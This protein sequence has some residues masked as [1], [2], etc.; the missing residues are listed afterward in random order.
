MATA[1]SSQMCVTTRVLS[2]QELCHSSTCSQPYRH[3]VTKNKLLKCLPDRGGLCECT[4]L[5]ILAM[6]LFSSGLFTLVSLSI[7]LPNN[8]RS[9]GCLPVPGAKLQ[10]NS[11]CS[12]T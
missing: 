10:T 4:E 9:Y 8:M 1:T 5:G 11:P 7:F 6:N 3:V 12:V 2:A